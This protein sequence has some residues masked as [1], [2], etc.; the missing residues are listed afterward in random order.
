[1][2]GWLDAFATLG[3]ARRDPDGTWQVTG[4]APG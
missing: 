4:D 2:E 3:L 1:M